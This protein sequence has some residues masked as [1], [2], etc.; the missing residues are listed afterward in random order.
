[1]GFDRYFGFDNT[2]RKTLEKLLE[3]GE[4]GEVVS[5][6]GATGIVVLAA[7]DV[8]ALPDTS[9]AANVA[10]AAVPFADLTAAANKVNEI[11][12]ALIAAGLMEAP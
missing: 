1:M 3:A 9:V 6:N 12:T 8:G 10:A 5:V 4:A 7:D 2:Q 11:I